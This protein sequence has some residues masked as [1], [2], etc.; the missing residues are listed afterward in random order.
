MVLT[1]GV[2][3]LPGFRNSLLLLKE[4]E[5]GYLAAE[6]FHTFLLADLSICGRDA[7]GIQEYSV[8]RVISGVGRPSLR[9]SKI[10]KNSLA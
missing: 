1:T 5:G 3:Y 7:T 6:P 2:I 8:Y 10:H 9:V 4:V